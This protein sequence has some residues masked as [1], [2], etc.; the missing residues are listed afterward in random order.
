MTH[1]TNHSVSIQDTTDV[2]AVIVGSL[3]SASAPIEQE[4][5]S[6]AT[7]G[8]FYPEQI[9]V[10]SQKP[11]IGFSSYDLPKV[12][13]ALGVTGRLLTE[14]VGTKPG[15]ALYQAKYNDSVI[16]AGATH[17]RL[18]FPKSFAMI[19]R[20]TC[21]HRQD[22][23]IEAEALAIFDATNN[24]VVIGVSQAL[25]TLPGSPG[26]WTLDAV[27][28]GGFT[29]DCNIQ[30]DIDFGVTAPSFG[31][32]SD[33]WDTHLNVDEIKPMISITSLDPESFA[34]AKVPLIGK[35]GA[36]ADCKIT[37]R[38]R[39]ESQAGYVAS[40]TAEHISIT[41][42][43]VMLVED[44]HNATGNQRAQTMLKMHCRFDDTNAPL[45]FDTTY[46]LA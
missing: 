9:S 21:S 30:V 26:R 8:R 44:A 24:P 23:V 33:I 2:S 6:N 19:R 28:I 45:L 15:I 7:A 41:A 38:K 31:C 22:A 4:V 40:A 10:V 5:Q 34:A 12:I 37:F 39:L 36:H 1:Y 18:Q 27:V 43:G 13:D 3:T 32:D 46:A 16:S 25:P 20:I 35:A 14:A 11:K 42:D 17:R 29:I